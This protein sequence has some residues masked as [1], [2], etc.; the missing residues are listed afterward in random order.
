MSWATVIASTLGGPTL[1]LESVLVS[2]ILV[3]PKVR[4]IRWPRRQR[5]TWWNSTVWW[6]TAATPH[7][8]R[9][10]ADRSTGPGSS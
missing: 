8:P 3:W 9:I 7:G 1:M 5:P 6:N 2:Q 4:V 10:C